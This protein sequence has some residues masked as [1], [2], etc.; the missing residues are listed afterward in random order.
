MPRHSGAP[1]SGGAAAHGSSDHLLLPPSSNHSAL[2]M[3]HAASASSATKLN[4]PLAAVH[5]EPSHSI[6]YGYTH[7]PEGVLDFQLD[8]H[9]VEQIVQLCGS[10]IKYR[11]FDLPLIFSSMA[12]DLSASKVE[13]LIA[14]LLT[15][16]FYHSQARSTKPQHVHFS[17]SF[18]DEVRFADPHDLAALIKW[19]LTRLGRV[20]E[21]PVPVQAKGKVQEEVN[22]MQQRGFLDLDAYMAWRDEEL[23]SDYALT[24]FDLFLKSISP[25]A[26]SLLFA[27]FSLLSSVTV[28]SIKNGMTPSKI[29]RIFGVLL[30]GLPEDESFARTYDAFAR[31]SNATEHLFLSY[32][33]YSLKMSPSRI[34]LTEIVKGYPGMLVSDLTAPGKQAN[35]VPLTQIERTVRLYSV[36]LLQSASELEVEPDCVEWTACRGP[37]EDEPR[38]PG[39]AAGAGA[40]STAGEPQL[41]ESY[42]KLINLRG[43]AIRKKTGGQ[44][45]RVGSESGGS[46]GGK[47]GTDS[48]K[49]TFPLRETQPKVLTQGPENRQWSDFATSGFTVNDHGFDKLRNIDDGLKEEMDRWPGERAE[50]N[51]R[52]RQT[53]KRLPHFPYDTTPRVVAS[54]SF[55]T[56]KGECAPGQGQQHVHPISRMDE[57]FAEV[58]AD[59]LVGCGWSNRDELTHRNANFV[60]VQYKSRPIE[61]AV[62]VQAA[63]QR[64]LL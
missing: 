61:S 47:S 7:L 63:A 29:S 54:P 11:G 4:H 8:L 53:Q 2:G 64:S 33:R 37:A 23:R 57:T 10:E 22:F 40:G 48:S 13:S 3:S 50:L 15:P 14:K 56:H 44:N 55:S 49:L 58:W 46:V 26:A 17:P 52:L 27:L 18:L 25:Q 38:R 34:R 32:I 31:G 19:A 5:A 59:Y 35:E 1:S 16:E 51:E 12:L 60:V 28:Y 24:A 62:G 6:Q 43:Q 36:D 9:G 21:V 30:F 45:G 39:G 41:S 42:R 20:F